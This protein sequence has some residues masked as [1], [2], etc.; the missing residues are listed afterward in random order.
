MNAVLIQRWASKSNHKQH[1]HVVI[2][3]RGGAVVAVGYNHDETHAE[4]AALGKV[5]PNK[6]K[7]LRIWSFRLRRDGQLGMAKPCKKCQQFL[8]ENGVKVVYYSGP[9]GK[10]ERM[11]L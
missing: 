7:G 5:W 3:E 1:H 11:K 9:D 10:M 4:V 8:R 6:R 2:V